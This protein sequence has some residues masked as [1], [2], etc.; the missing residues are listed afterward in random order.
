VLVTGASGFVGS[1]V[2][3]RLREEGAD[4]HGVSRAVR[5]SPG[6][7]WWQADLT[8]ADE[9]ARLVTRIRPDTIYHLAGYPS[10]SRSLDAVLPSLRDNLVAAVNVLIAAARS[11]CGLVLMAG[12]L[13]EPEPVAG[14]PVPTSPY[15]AA[16]HAAGSFG[17]MF[18][19]LNDLPVINLRVFMVYGPGQLDQAKLVPY[20]VTSLLRGEAPKLS[21]G[22]RPVDWVYVQDV[23]DA[24]LTAAR[25]PDLAGETIDVGSGHLVTVRSMVEQIVKTMGTEIEPEFGALSDR[26]LETVRTADVEQTR[27]RLGWEPRTSLAEGLFATV[28][29]FKAEHARESSSQLKESFGT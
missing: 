3:R 22:G 5:A 17:R 20:V 29:W 23:A 10:G 9:A 24:F 25:R 11:E 18:V 14:E 27:D 7:R 4:V 16:K 6:I 15:A 12:S 26:P 21:S 13:E 19:A 1:H 2:Y 8:D 28:E